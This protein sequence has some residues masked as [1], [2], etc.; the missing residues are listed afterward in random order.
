LFSIT[1]ISMGALMGRTMCSRCMNFA[2]PFNHVDQAVR[3]AFFDRNPVV[4]QA[5]LGENWNKAKG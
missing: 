5:W 2:C 4:A 1:V 3:D